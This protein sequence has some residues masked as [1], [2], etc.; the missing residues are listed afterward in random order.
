MTGAPRESVMTVREI[1]A[2]LDKPA[3]YLAAARRLAAMSHRDNLA[4]V[5][6]FVVSTFTFD[7]VVPYLV[8]ESARHDLDAAVEVGGYGQLEQ[9]VLASGSRLHAFAPDVVIIATRIE[10]IAPAIATD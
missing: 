2:D 3:S 1:V 10:D 8:V 5:R 6:V 7:L 4:P 9:L